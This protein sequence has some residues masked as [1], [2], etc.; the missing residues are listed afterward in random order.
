MAW[1]SPGTQHILPIGKKK[2]KKG[3][4]FIASFTPSNI[5]PQGPQC[6][7]RRLTRSKTG[8]SCVLKH[9]RAVMCRME[10]SKEESIRNNC[11]CSLCQVSNH[12]THVDTHLLH[13][14][15]KESKDSVVLLELSMIPEFDFYSNFLPWSP[16]LSHF[17]VNTAT[18][19]QTN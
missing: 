11:Q 15:P 10:W 18:E 1:V 8:L 6:P 14:T 2:K 4:T 7:Q 13:G 5:L 17:W 12:F 3:K 16:V 19:F 9:V